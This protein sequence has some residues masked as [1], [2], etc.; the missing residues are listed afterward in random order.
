MKYKLSLIGLGISI[1]VFSISLIFKIDLFEIMIKT[2]ASLEEFE[3]DEFIIPLFIFL[4][5]SFIDQVKIQNS[6]KIENEK[7]KIY[8]AMLSSTHHIL[9]NFINQMQLFKMTAESTPEF[10]HEILS[11]YDVVINDATTQIEA[12]GAIT[13]INEISINKSVKPK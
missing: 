5:F 11:L 8:K 13:K 9:N 4:I 3:I 7:L 10:D 2:M 6:Q 1:L 12:L